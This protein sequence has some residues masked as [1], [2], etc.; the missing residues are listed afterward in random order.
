[1]SHVSMYNKIII[2]TITTILGIQPEL[3]VID[4]CYCKGKWR[5]HCWK[6]I[7]EIRTIFNEKLRIMHFFFIK[8][9]GGKEW[10]KIPKSGFIDVLNNCIGKRWQDFFYVH[11]YLPN[12]LTNCCAHTFILT[13]VVSNYYIK[14]FLLSCSV[15][16]SIIN[17]IGLKSFT[18]FWTN[19]GVFPCIS[20]YKMY[21]P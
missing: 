2:Y 6:N 5:G 9:W 17:R 21:I 19:K 12:L 4:L 3:R 10:I 16:T 14:N 13:H 1:M 20:E 11:F 8:R 18:I 15:P 7:C